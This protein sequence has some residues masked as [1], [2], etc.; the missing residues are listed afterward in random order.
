MV[1]G[2]LVPLEERPGP[3]PSDDEDVGVLRWDVCPAALTLA[4]GS[5]VGAEM[6]P[7]SRKIRCS[8]AR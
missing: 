4:A 6:T 7:R 8:R 1:R 5:H 2:V 3:R